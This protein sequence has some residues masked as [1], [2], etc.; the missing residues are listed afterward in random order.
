MAGRHQVVV[1]LSG[2]GLAPAEVAF[3]VTFPVEPA[4]PGMIGDVERAM[5]SL[6]GLRETQMLDSGFSSFAFRFEYAPPDRLHYTF[7]GPDGRVGE[8]TIVGGRRFDREGSVWRASD[9]GTPQR[10]PGI[11]YGA[12]QRRVRV[13]GSERVDGADTLVLAFVVPGSSLDIHWVLWV[14]AEDLRI[15]RYTMMALGH[16]MRGSYTDFDARIE[17]APPATE[18]P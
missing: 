4:R 12:D 10:V 15:R 14:G 2:G 16:Y 18:R 17:I 6:H 9:L 11:T 8:V 7:V 3:D 13:I 1:Q 5:N